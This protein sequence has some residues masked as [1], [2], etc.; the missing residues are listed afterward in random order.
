[1][2]ARPRQRR[3]PGAP[4][5]RASEL[6]AA[7]HQRLHRRRQHQRQH[8]QRQALQDANS[9]HKHE[10]SNHT[11]FCEIIMRLH[12]NSQAPWQKYQHN[13]QAYA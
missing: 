7:V 13:R 11:P 6:G 9:R 8:R 1:M 2:T 5:A 10:R 4:A 3:R 12:F